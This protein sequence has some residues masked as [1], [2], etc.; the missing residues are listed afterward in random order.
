MSSCPSR[1]SPASTHEIGNMTHSTTLA[2]KPLMAAICLTAGLV[3]ASPQ[4]LASGGGGSFNSSSGR[5]I[6]KTYELGKSFYKS[7]QADG[8]KLAYC[9]Q[10]GDDLKKLSR[11]TVKPFKNGSV[12]KFVDSLY[13]C[14]DPNTKIADVV[15]ESQGDAILYYL[16]KRYKLRLKS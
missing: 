5:S 8:S 14:A 9:V 3:I 10:T 13:D 1:K 16:N 11:R 15:P 6:D 12:S 7:R 2:R 4:L